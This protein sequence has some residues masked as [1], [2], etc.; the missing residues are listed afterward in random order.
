MVNPE[1]EAGPTVTK[2]RNEEH[3]RRISITKKMMS[4]FG[5]VKVKKELMGSQIWA[6][7]VTLAWMA[8]KTSMVL[9]SAALSD[10]MIE[11]TDVDE[12]Q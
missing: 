8:P 7:V 6:M 2:T 10:K 1:V 4:E 12:V 5:D 11:E 9:A 3:V